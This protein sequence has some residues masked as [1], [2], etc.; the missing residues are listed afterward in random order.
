MSTSATEF[1]SRHDL[2]PID[3][4]SPAGRKASRLLGELFDDVAERLR[5]EGKPVPDCIAP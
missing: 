1:P 2:E 4:D 5:R 3:P